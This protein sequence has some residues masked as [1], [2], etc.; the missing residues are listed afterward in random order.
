MRR[1]PARHTCAATGRSACVA[2]SAGQPLGAGDFPTMGTTETPTWSSHDAERTPE[3]R[4][5][6][7]VARAR[8]GADGRRSAAAFKAI[9]RSGSTDE[10]K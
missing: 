1:D 9:R 3:E 6:K 5:S 10:E 4:A 7:R 2:C 8:R